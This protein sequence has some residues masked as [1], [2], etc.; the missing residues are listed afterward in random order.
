MNRT[1]NI[2]N[3][4]LTIKFG[5]IL[6]AESEIIVSSDD[7]MLSMG[8]GI[9]RTIRIGAGDEIRNDA[10]KKIPASLGDVVVT[11]VTLDAL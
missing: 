10:K 5:N 1:Y 3:S 6:D 8:G 11:T 2:N 4:Q 7:Y 9:S